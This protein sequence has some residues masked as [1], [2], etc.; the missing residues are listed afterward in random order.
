MFD[1]IEVA[2]WSEIDEDAC[3]AIIFKYLIRCGF[4]FATH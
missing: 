2:V 3:H 4:R 1:V